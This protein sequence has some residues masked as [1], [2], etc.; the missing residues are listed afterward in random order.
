MRDRAGAVLSEA[1]KKEG[2]AEKKLAKANRMMAE[3]Q[4]ALVRETAQ[5]KRE[6]QIELQ[7]KA[8]KTLRRQSRQ[9]SGMTVV[10]LVA[11]LIQ[12]AAFLFLEKDTAATIPQWFQ[13]RY[14]NIQWLSQCIRDFYQHLYL[15]ITA[16]ISTQATTGIMTLVSVIIA[17]VI[18]SLMRM[19]LRYLLRK[20]KKRWEFYDCMDVDLI[21]KYAIVGIA[22]MGFS[23]S[24]VVV[25]LLFIPFRLN[26]ISWW[27]LI[28][29]VMELLYFYYD[30]HSF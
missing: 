22:F 30:G 18:F 10:L 21:K 6:M 16:E 2:N 29:G 24:M 19:G 14:K 13:G 11:Y 1:A 15:K 7:E 25:N 9:L 26:V 5:I 12:L 27:I 3:Y 8:D 28:S 20:W 17:I 23:I 4:T